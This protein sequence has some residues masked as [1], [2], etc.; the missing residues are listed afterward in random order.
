MMS[1][2]AERKFNKI[3]DHRDALASE[4]AR[5]ISSLNAA[6]GK[7]VD[8]SI[9]LEEDPD[10]HFAANG[11]KQEI[12]QDFADVVSSLN[13]VLPTISLIEQLKNETITVEQFKTTLNKTNFDTV[14]YQK[15]LTG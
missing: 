8:F 14:A 15:S 3:M 12:R 9:L 10:G 11:D 7:A 4:A 5:A 6:V 2:L 13:A 1:K